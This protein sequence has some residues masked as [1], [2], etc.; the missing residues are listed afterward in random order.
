MA[1]EVWEMQRAL[2]RTALIGLGA[3][4]NA[5][6]YGPRYLPNMGWSDEL[7]D[8]GRSLLP[9]EKLSRDVTVSMQEN[10]GRDRLHP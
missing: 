7:K 4:L 2:R 8:H 6:A 10:S 9:E 3:A 1:R 5:P